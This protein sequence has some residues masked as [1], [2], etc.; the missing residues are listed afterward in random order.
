MK[1]IASLAAFGLS[2]T[3]SLLMAQAAVTGGRTEVALDTTTLQSAASLTLSSVS[4][5]VPAGTVVPDSVAFSINATD[6]SPL[7]TDFVYTPGD[8]PTGFFAGE[9]EHTGSVFF[10]NDAVEVGNFRIGFDATRATGSNTGFF[11]ES[12][13]GIEAVLFDTALATDPGL[14]ATG[15]ALELS[16]DLLVSPEFA[17]FLQDNSLAS[18]DLTGADVGDARIIAVTPEPHAAVLAALAAAAAAASRRR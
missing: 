1:S 2:L 18:A 3:P 13:T 10:N 12:T 5:D 17:Q 16:V 8:F 11:I 6:A 9:I 4:P 14:V 7:P 15:A